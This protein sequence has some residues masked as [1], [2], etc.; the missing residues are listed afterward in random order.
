[1]KTLVCLLTLLFQVILAHGQDQHTDTT[2]I[3]IETH[4]GNEFF[5]TI[6]E[7]D[8]VKVLF[9]SQKYGTIDIQRK[10]IKS[11]SSID[12]NLIIDGKYWFPNRQSSRYFWAPN[13]Y[14]LKRGEGYYQNIYIFWNHF[15]TGITDNFSLGV[16]VIPLF[17][18][19]G[20]PTPVMIAPKLSIPIIE[21]WANLGTG[22]LIGTVLGTESDLYGMVY[23]TTTFGT[24]DD[25]VSLGFSYGFADAKWMDKPLLNVSILARTG[26][27]GYVISENYYVPRD[28]GCLS[29]GG[30]RIWKNVSLDYLLAIPFSPDMESFIAFPIIGF[31]IP[32]SS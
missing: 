32:F 27:R 9:K 24:R 6:V 17:L 11:R 10:N 7:E 23:A 18:F 2:L 15:S 8:S 29:I 22:A 16:T 19:N 3:H 26:P 14:G 31:V 5:G 4:E 25:N 28:G 1:M 12:S 30:R 13:G 21:N 20:S